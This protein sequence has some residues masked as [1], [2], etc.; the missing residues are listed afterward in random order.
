MDA[1]KCAPNRKELMLYPCVGP[2][3]AFEALGTI[4]SRLKSL[5]NQSLTLS[6]MAKRHE[7][8]HRSIKEAAANPQERGQLLL[9][10]ATPNR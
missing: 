9:Q 4:E 10:K 1:I 6:E 3:K 5:R 8:L 7:E 2:V